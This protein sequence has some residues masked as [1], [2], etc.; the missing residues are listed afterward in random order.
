M[1]FVLLAV[2]ISQ[3]LTVNETS[4]KNALSD[5]YT[6]PINYCNAK[7]ESTICQDLEDFKDDITGLKDKIVSLVQYYLEPEADPFTE[8][9]IPLEYPAQ[10][11][12]LLSDLKGLF[13]ALETVQS[14]S[15][16]TLTN[17]FDLSKVL[18]SL[19]NLKHSNHT[20]S[21]SKNFEAMEVNI[22][23][24]KNDDPESMLSELLKGVEDLFPRVVI[25]HSK[26]LAQI[27]SAQV[28]CGNCT[29]QVSL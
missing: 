25:A 17:L 19:E 7:S 16:S 12:T 6:T 21:R 26:I 15:N 9:K 27:F 5:A 20:W 18:S 8:Q 14:T 4:I 1:Q 24:P 13:K 11:G 3:A 28:V 10:I 2:L 29:I 23:T 22:G